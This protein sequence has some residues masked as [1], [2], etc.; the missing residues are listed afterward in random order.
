MHIHEK[1]SY[2]VVNHIEKK[3]KKNDVSPA[4]KSSR[5]VLRLFSGLQKCDSAKPPVVAAF[6]AALFSINFYSLYR[7]HALIVF[8]FMCLLLKRKQEFLILSM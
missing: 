2:G 8:I 5:N 7:S 4:Y 1:K 6:A 3:K